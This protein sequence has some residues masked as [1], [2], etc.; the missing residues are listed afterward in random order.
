LELYY[1]GYGHAP[2]NIYIYAPAQ[3]TLMVV[4]VI[5]PGWVPYRGLSLSR[6]VPGLFRQ[7]DEINAFP[8]ETLVGG[9]VNRTGTHADVVTQAEF[10][11][12]LKTAS[13]NALQENKF[14]SVSD[15]ADR[16]NP[17]A[18]A[19]NYMDRVA[20]QCVNTMTTK[21]AARLGGFDVYIWDHCYA[22]AESLRA[23]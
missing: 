7:L 12:D 15:P 11:N 2:G 3:K 6:N 1:H 14:G 16:N 20:P 5:S 8:F 18:L 22:M 21:W 13:K 4:D 10:M 17:W 19:D 23:D 9:H